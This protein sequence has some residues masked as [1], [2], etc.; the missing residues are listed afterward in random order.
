MTG[1]S[2]ACVNWLQP[3][4][5]GPPARRGESGL[6]LVELVLV[7]AILG[8]LS[9]IAVPVLGDYID[10]AR[11][12]KAIADIRQLSVAIMNFEMGTGSLPDSLDELKGGAR[13]D[14]WGNPY[15]YLNII[16]GPPGSKGKVRKDHNLVPLNSEYDLYS[17]GKDGS[18][19]PPLTAKASRDDIIRASDGAFIGLAS[20]Y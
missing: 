14:P 18:S 16:D 2:L 5:F 10:E 3:G 11:Q 15:Q 13:L 8:T 20:E 7:V 9:A 17:M 12:T 19:K 4:S 1:L 6:T